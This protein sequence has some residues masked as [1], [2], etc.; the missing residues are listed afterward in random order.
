[1]GYPVYKCNGRNHAVSLTLTHDHT[2]EINI[3]HENCM[4]QSSSQYAAVI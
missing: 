3:D 4:I 1:M 2:G